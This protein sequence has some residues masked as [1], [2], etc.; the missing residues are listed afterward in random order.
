MSD[1]K[2]FPRKGYNITCNDKVVG[3]I[4]SGTVS[5]IIDKAIALAYVE[6]EYTKEGTISNFQIR[7][8]EIP[9]TVIKLPFVKR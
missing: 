4:T 9:A 1:D 8:K 6:T 7:N 3:I 5:P 2:A